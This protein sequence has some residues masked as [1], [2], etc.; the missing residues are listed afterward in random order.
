MP[1]DHAG[2]GM[3]RLQRAN[4][5]GDLIHRLL[6]QRDGSNMRGNGDTRMTPE[7][8]ILRQRLAGEHV[9]RGGGQLPLFVS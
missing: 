7:R 1:V 3:P 2:R 5:G 9:Q 6:R 8:V 4:V